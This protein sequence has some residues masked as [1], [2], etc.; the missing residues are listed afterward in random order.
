MFEILEA[1]PPDPILGL[2]EAF[3]KDP[4]PN[5]INLGA[6]VYKDEK[7]GTPTLSAVRKAEQKVWDA[8]AGKAYLPI[9]GAP[10]FAV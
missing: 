4:N 5:K 1:A 8:N 10:E 9:S 7:G 2:T 6:G 3:K